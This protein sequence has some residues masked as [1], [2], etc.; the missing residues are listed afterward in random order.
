MASSKPMLNFHWR[1]ATHQEVMD[2]KAVCA[3]IHH[4][5]GFD[6]ELREGHGAYDDYYIL[7]Q[8]HRIETIDGV[9]FEWKPI[10]IADETA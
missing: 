7:E 8:Q 2:G 10:T 6:I 9:T 1:K 5:S 3:L 4:S